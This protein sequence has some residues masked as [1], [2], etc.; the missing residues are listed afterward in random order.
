MATTTLN[1][2]LQT[3]ALSKR[4]VVAIGDFLIIKLLTDTVTT[5]ENLNRA[6]TKSLADPAL[7]SEIISVAPNKILTESIALDDGGQLYFSQNYLVDN[8]DYVSA[9]GKIYTLFKAI[10]EPITTSEN[11]ITAMAKILTDTPLVSSSGLLCNQ[12]Y[13]VD[14]TYFSEDYVGESRA[15]S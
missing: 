9:L 11:Y 2:K 10:S 8:G 6:T 5:A 14:S 3:V 12:N 1:I 7:T 15:F 4:L 13:F